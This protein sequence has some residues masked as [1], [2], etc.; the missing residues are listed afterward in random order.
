MIFPKFLRSK[1]P[2]KYGF[3]E[4]RMLEKV[5]EKVGHLAM[6][7]FIPSMFYITGMDAYNRLSIS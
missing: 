6:E 4:N 7:I 2:P 5:I 1:R 3:F